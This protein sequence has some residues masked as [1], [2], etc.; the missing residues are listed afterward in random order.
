MENNSTEIET[1]HQKKEKIFEQHVLEVAGLTFLALFF[2][3]GISYK[4]YFFAI[5]SFMEKTGWY[6]FYLIIAVVANAIAIYHLKAYRNAVTCMTGMMIG[7]TIGMISGFTLGYLVGATN[8]MFMGSMYGM[9]VGMAAGAWTGKCCG[10]M[11]LMEGMMAG[12]MGG[13]MGA[14][15]SVMMLFDHILLFTPFFLLACIIILFGLGHLVYKEHAS[16]DEK[17]IKPYSLSLFFVVCFMVTTL[18]VIIMIYVP[19]AGLTP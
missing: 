19:K 14:M 1:P 11:G 4:F 6:I 10:I 8:G 18:T 16:S 5:P 17:I 15:L 2:L 7:M 13:S 12:L 3:F 9:I